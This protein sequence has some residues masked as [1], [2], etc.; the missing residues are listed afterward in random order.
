MVPLLVVLCLSQNSSA[1]GIA[2]AYSAILAS[3]AQYASLSSGAHSRDPLAI[4]PFKL[5]PCR[6]I[7]SLSLSLS[8]SLR[9]GFDGLSERT[10]LN[11]LPA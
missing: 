11:V 7:L 3:A 2:K 1:D 9:G 5:G 4:A 6:E 8:L 10:A